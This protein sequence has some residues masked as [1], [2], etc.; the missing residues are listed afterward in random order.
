MDVGEKVKCQEEHVVE[1]KPNLSAQVHDTKG[2]VYELV[3][4]VGDKRNQK[5]QAFGL[6]GSWKEKVEHSQNQQ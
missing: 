5:Q 4:T 3:H 1:S 6:L 2:K